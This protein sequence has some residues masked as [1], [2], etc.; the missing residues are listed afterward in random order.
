MSQIAYYACL[1]KIEQSSIF[2]KSTC[3]VECN[4]IF[5]YHAEKFEENNKNEIMYYIIRTL[6][7]EIP[8]LKNKY[9]IAYVHDSLRN[10]LFFRGVVKLLPAK[11]LV[12]M[13]DFYIVDGGASVKLAQFFSCGEL[14][15]FI[16]SKTRHLG[17]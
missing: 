5:C 14:N 12:K 17:R 11:F 3:D 10:F 6:N 16:K 8:K 1:D 7:E 2:T 13:K 4:I 9:S 15:A